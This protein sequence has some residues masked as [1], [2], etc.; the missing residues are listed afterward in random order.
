MIPASGAEFP[1]LVDRRIPLTFGRRRTQIGTEVQQRR[2]VGVNQVIRLLL[3][4]VG[5]RSVRSR[6]LTQRFGVQRPVR[7]RTGTFPISMVD[8]ATLNCTA[9]AGDT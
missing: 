9:V 3:A 1:Q 5:G 6:V 4:A 7:M 8:V 2:T